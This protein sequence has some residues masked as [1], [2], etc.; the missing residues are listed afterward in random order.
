MCTLVTKGDKIAA[1]KSQ[2]TYRCLI[3]LEYLSW[4]EEA[5]LSSLT[6][7]WKCYVALRRETMLFPI[8]DKQPSCLKGQCATVAVICHILLSKKTQVWKSTI[9][10]RKSPLSPHVLWVLTLKLKNFHLWARL[11]TDGLHIEI[12]YLLQKAV[13]HW[14]DCWAACFSFIL[15][16]FYVALLGYILYL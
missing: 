3:A 16:P 4:T 13:F 2:L 8:W 7:R 15:N 1:T 9:S 14:L 5:L 6:S 12:R 11:Q 10:C